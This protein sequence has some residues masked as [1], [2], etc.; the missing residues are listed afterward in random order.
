MQGVHVSSAI[1]DEQWRDI[2]ASG[3]SIYEFDTEA[4]AREAL[5]LLDDEFV[6]ATPADAPDDGEAPPRLE[7]AA[8]SG[9]D[10]TPPQPL[11]ATGLV[12]PT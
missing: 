8:T 6:D 12:A 5:E 9:E 3:G 4:E 1:S 11:K 2:V 10:E 7:N